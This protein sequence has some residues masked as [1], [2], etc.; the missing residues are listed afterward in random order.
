MRR[1]P[2]NDRFDRSYLRAGR[3]R[4]SD[5]QA[6][7]RVE[8]S[9]L[10]EDNFIAPRTPVNFQQSR[11]TRPYVHRPLT[12]QKTSGVLDHKSSFAWIQGRAASRWASSSRGISTSP[13]SENS[14][15]ASTSNTTSTASCT[16][17]AHGATSR[18]W[19]SPWAAPLPHATR[20]PN[21]SN[22]LAKSQALCWTSLGRTS[23]GR[24]SPPNRKNSSST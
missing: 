17:A 5:P 20:A 7:F 16:G 6:S 23:A 18:S 24:K 8:S 2:Y 15:A 13:P 4:N 10:P 22:R 1:T 12:T 9:R 3:P 14:S 11:P 21:R 19:A